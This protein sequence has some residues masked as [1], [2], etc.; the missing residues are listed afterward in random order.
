ML[1]ALA[2]LMVCAL[3]FLSAISKQRADACVLKNDLY[4]RYKHDRDTY[5][6]GA[7]FGLSILVSFMILCWLCNITIA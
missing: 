2:S 7:L 6:V 4:N 5:L 3:F 1:V